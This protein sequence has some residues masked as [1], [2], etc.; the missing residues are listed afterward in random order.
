LLPG[1]EF[2]RFLDFTTSGGVSRND[3]LIH[4]MV[5]GAPFGGVGNSRTSAYHGQAGF[6]RLTHKRTAVAAGGPSG[7]SD[8]FIGRVLAS[9]ELGSALDQGIAAAIADNKTPITQ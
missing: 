2:Q 9:D 3:G 4:A 5:P 1:T 6:D 7:V 8:G